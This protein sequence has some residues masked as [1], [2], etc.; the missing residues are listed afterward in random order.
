M[1]R[2]F[3]RRLEQAG[4]HGGFRQGDVL[5]V[6][7]EIVIRRGRRAEGAAA[8]IGPVEVELQD[9]VLGQVAFEPEGQER[10][11]DLALERALVRQEQ[12]LGELLGQRGAALDV[13]AAARVHGDGAERPDRVDAPMLV[14][15]PV[16]GRDQRLDENVGKF[17]DA[18][19]IVVLDAAP[20]DLGAVAVEE[21]HGEVRRLEPV[22]AGRV[23]GRLGERQHHHAAGEPERDRLAR[24]VEGEA[25]DAGDPEAPLDLLG[26]AAIGL[27]E[28]APALVEAVVHPG[29]EA[30]HPVG[31]AGPELGQPVGG[32]VLGHCDGSSGSA[33]SRSSK[34]RIL[35]RDGKP[36]AGFQGLYGALARRHDVAGLRRSLR[37][38]CPRG[39]GAAEEGTFRSR[40]PRPC[41]RSGASKALEQPWPKP[42]SPPRAR[43]PPSRRRPRSGARRPWRD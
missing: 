26:V 20:P 6:L 8:H 35:A 9:L 11:V 22:L 2:V 36:F 25:L 29:V 38:A 4:Q 5:E 3:R 33:D 14:E 42:A 19:R 27:A 21:G 23:E 13:A 30:E 10:L 41:R 16:L 24:E 40:Y 37:P 34:P 12:V 39:Q 17:V 28:R 7:A 15:A 18:Q 1:G 31:Q 43:P 32:P